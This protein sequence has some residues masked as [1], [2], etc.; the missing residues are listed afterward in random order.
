MESKREIRQIGKFS[1]NRNSGNSC[2]GSV[3]ILPS[4]RF[5][6]QGPLRQAEQTQY[7]P[8]LVTS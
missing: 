2:Q 8:Y 5:L 3:I 7:N 1:E 6:T 4:G